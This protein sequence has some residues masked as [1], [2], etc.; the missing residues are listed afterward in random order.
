MDQEDQNIGGG[1]TSLDE[2][3]DALP[4]FLKPEHK[5][6]I[7]MR[8]LGDEDYDETSLHIPKEYWEGK[9]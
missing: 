2:I 7:E 3:R 9:D 5:R 1:F 4:K 6:D 8:K